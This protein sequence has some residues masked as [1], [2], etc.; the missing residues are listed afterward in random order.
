MLLFYFCAFLQSWAYKE[1]M[2]NCRLN[3][4]GVA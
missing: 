2:F 3:F 1:Y 4:R